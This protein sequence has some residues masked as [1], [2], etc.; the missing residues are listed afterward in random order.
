MTG[1]RILLLASL[2]VLGVVTLAL[3]RGEEQRAVRAVLRAEATIVLSVVGL[4]V[5]DLCGGGNLLGLL[6]S[7]VLSVTEVMLS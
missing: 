1:V 7:L 3:L 6:S 2:A 4:G 5:V